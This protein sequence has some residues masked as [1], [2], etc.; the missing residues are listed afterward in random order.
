MHRVER[1]VMVSTFARLDP[2]KARAECWNQVALS[3]EENSNLVF[4]MDEDTYRG[5][6]DYWA[7]QSHYTPDSAVLLTADRYVIRKGTEERVVKDRYQ[8]IFGQPSGAE[9]L[10]HTFVKF[11]NGMTFYGPIA[12]VQE[13][14]TVYVAHKVAEDSGTMIVDASNELGTFLVE[15]MRKHPPKPIIT[16]PSFIEPKH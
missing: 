14:I 2:I 13:A 1:R 12:A 5:Q 8:D 4:V 16:I 11:D 6:G 3:R 10:T 15:L 7:L 9:R